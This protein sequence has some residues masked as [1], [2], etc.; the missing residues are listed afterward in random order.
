MKRYI[1]VPFT[2][3]KTE[4]DTE[5]VRGTPLPQ[6][7]RSFRYLPEEIRALASEA[8][9]LWRDLAVERAN[10]YGDHTGCLLAGRMAVDATRWEDGLVI[11]EAIRQRMDE[12]SSPRW[13]PEWARELG[14]QKRE[15]AR[16]VARRAEKELVNDLDP[17]VRRV[18]VAFGKARAKGATTESWSCVVC[19]Q[20]T[21]GRCAKCAVPLHVRACPSRHECA[22]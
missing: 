10:P 16:I 2:E 20:I 12:K 13:I 19:R 17:E 1:P 11:L 5:K 15:Q 22:A 21:D 14:G 18:L 7:G 8:Y 3:T 6:G 4:T 9:A